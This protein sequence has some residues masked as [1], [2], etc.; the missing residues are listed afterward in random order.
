MNYWRPNVKGIRKN[1]GKFGSDNKLRFLNKK[2]SC[3]KRKP[4]INKSLHFVQLSFKNRALTVDMD[5]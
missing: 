2:D 1:G 3:T 4:L 5:K